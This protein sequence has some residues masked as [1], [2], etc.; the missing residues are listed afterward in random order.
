VAKP[1]LRL[2]GL[3]AGVSTVRLRPRQLSAAE[4]AEISSAVF[5]DAPGEFR[6]Y[7]FRLATLTA[8]STVIAAFGLI[9]NSPAVVIGAMLVAPLMQPIM[10][11]A[12]ALALGRP[13]HEITCLL[14]TALATLEAIGFAVLIGLLVPTFRVVTLTPELL[15][16]T[17]PALLDLGIAVT[18]GAAGAYVTVRP[19]SL[20]AIAGAAIAVALVP[21][22]A[23]CGVLLAHGNGSLAVG[24]LFLFLTN[25]VGIILAAVVVFLLTGLV[26]HGAVT[27]RRLLAMVL[28]VVAVLAV[29][30]PLG[31]RSITTY[32]R[33][34]DEASVR[35]LIFPELRADGL[36]IQ[37]LVVIAPGGNLVASIDVI[38]PSPPPAAADLARRLA[39]DLGRPVRVILRWTKREESVGNSA[40]AP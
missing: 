31:R 21:P 22:L 38:G 33:S 1:P 26:A 3:L 10:G 13:R 15:S 4:R 17:T 34:Q 39:D 12:A 30:Y 20:G 8:L 11:F 23:A 24:A 40:A 36:G 18:A 27:R 7:V 5:F 9:A 28:P 35:H 29:A 25:L 2:R 32:D 14:L 19:R 16:R 6:P 37:S